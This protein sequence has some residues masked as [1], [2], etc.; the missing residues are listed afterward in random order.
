M[1][2]ALV[3]LLLLAVFMIVGSFLSSDIFTNSYLLAVLSGLLLL[4]LLLC[5]IKQVA[6]VI[7]GIKVSGDR[8]I[9]VWISGFGSPVMHIGVLLIIAGMMMGQFTGFSDDISLAAGDTYSY[10]GLDFEVRL[11]SF[12]IVYDEN[13]NI[14]DYIST[15]TV[16][17]DGVEVLTTEITVNDPLEYKGVKFYQ[18]TYGWVADVLIVDTETG[19]TFL[20]KDI[21]LSLISSTSGIG[22][23]DYSMSYMTMEFVLLPDQEEEGVIGSLTPEANNPS[24]FFRLYYGDMLMISED[25]SL[26]ETSE[27]SGLTITFEGLE[28]YSGLEVSCKPELPLIFTG[29]VV[30]IAGLIIVFYVRRPVNRGQEEAEI[31]H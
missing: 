24:L 22:L 20:D 5:C 23:A 2:F 18:S 6:K 26:G 28:R 19:E 1:K 12:G 10:E 8:G 21:Y 17:E 16:I 15:V 11:D 3:I 13:Y 30:F 27:I 4:S 14:T 25:T 9:R 29:S 31:E 7:G